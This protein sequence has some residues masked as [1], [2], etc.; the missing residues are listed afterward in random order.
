MRNK[1]ILL[2]EDNPGD[3]AL[4]LRAFRKSNIAHE[5]VVARDGAEALDYLLGNGKHADRDRRDFPAV[6]LLDLKLPKVDGKEVLRLIRADERVKLTPVVIFTS[7]R[8]EQDVMDGFALGCNSYICKPVNSE[9][10]TDA[11]KQIAGY[12]LVLNEHVALN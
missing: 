5:I 8:E 10:F 1:T 7:S 11:V 12:W 2:V 6:V 3:E 9:Q 4:A